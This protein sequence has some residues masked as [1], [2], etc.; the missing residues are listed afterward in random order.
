MSDKF[1]TPVPGKLEKG[2]ASA[3]TRNL[4]I[5]QTYNDPPTDELMGVYAAWANEYD[6][7][8]I[9]GHGYKAPEDA[10]A[11]FATLGLAK[12]A[13]VL[14][15]GCGTG[16][17]GLL[18]RN[19]GF[20]H[21]DGA[22]LSAEML[23]IAK[24]RDVYNSLFKLDMTADYNIAEADTYEAVI[25][26]GVFGFGPPHVPHLH[27]IMGAA[28]PGAP[29]LITVNGAGWKV[30]GWDESFA[31]H[32]TEHRITCARNK[33]IRHMTKDGIDAR[34]IELRRDKLTGS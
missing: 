19:A 15:A 10:V 13:R 4:M 14:D 6:N 22:D 18:L 16:I 23:A 12:N 21:I 5:K 29:V 33:T 3:M 30:R 9:N 31:L 34:L 8:L 2:M 11:E 1:D 26:V 17:V 20:T 28:K 7:D 25:C 27:Y 24:K 32:L